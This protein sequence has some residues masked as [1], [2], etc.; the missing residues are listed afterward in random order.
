MRQLID[1]AF[2]LQNINRYNTI[3]RLKEESVA[4]HSYQVIAGVKVI[5]DVLNVNDEVRL[6]AYNAAIMHDIPESIIN[7]ITW[8]A[9]QL[10]GESFKEQLNQIEETLIFGY[11]EQ[12]SK[13]L[14][15]NRNLLHIT[16]EFV[17]SI[18][19][20][21][22]VDSV[23]KYAEREVKLGNEYFKDI[24]KGSKERYEEAYKKMKK[25]QEEYENAKKFK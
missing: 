24:V 20:L 9:K 13:D 17:K 25:M 4:E 6:R 12:A 15:P 11:D 7:D 10:F 3:P 18:V 1:M 22:D 16:C 5:C 2:D 21:A 23:I 8:D 14:F 19:E